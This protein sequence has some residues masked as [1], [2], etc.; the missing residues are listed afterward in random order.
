MS[1][2]ADPRG[3]H[4]D[5]LPFP[6]HAARLADD[7]GVGLQM[8][9]LGQPLRTQGRTPLL[10]RG[11]DQ[12]QLSGPAAHAGQRRPGVDR[13]GD[14]R[15]SCLPI[16]GRGGH[17]RTRRGRTDRPAKRDR[18]PG[19]L[20]SRWPD[21]I[22]VW[23]GPWPGMRTI[24]LGRD[25]SALSTVTSGTPSSTSLSSTSRATARSSPGGVGLGVAMRRR[26]K[27]NCSSAVA[28]RK[29]RTSCSG[30]A[31]APAG[32]GIE[33][34]TSPPGRAGTAA[35]VRAGTANPRALGCSDR[36]GRG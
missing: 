8:T 25:G 2:R 18:S 26:A 24:R 7:G 17:R 14:G 4:P 32:S 10:V 34:V 9:L 16:P 33:P 15:P 29:A 6:G 36:G 23:P 12:M 1:K 28:L 30:S 19:G 13:G 11:Q 5:A 3:D 35:S 20:V 22:R 27:A 31:G 21:R